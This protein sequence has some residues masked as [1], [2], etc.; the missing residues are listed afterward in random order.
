MDEG[1][2]RGGEGP[3]GAGGEGGGGDEDGAVPS[4]RVLSIECTAF[5]TTS[6]GN[7]GGDGS[8]SGGGGG[9]GAQ[10]V[11]AVSVSVVACPLAYQAQ[12]QS[13]RRGTLLST[14]R[15]TP[16]VYLVDVEAQCILA[17]LE[18]HGQHHAMCIAP[19]PCGGLV[20]GGNKHDAT[21][22]LWQ[23]SQ[24][25]GAPG[26]EGVRGREGEGGSSLAGNAVVVTDPVRLPRPGYCF[27]LVAL[28]ERTEGSVVVAL[29]GARYNRVE[30]CL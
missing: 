20:T 26:R 22:Q 15:S 8:G 1:D 25:A 17:V 28:P 5:L 12:V 27:A 10:K 23:R 16:A 30:I 3:A 29:A 9:G 11:L 19:L 7:D 2:E 14:G 21:T 4:G 18:G 6:V 13:A 24:W